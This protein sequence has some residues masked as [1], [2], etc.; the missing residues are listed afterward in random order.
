MTKV[1]EAIGVGKDYVRSA[2][3]R[4]SQHTLRDSLASWGKAVV[5][6][7]PKG[8]R[9]SERFSALKG[10]SFDLHEGE[11][12]G[13]LGPNGSGKSTLL[14][15]I[16]QVTAPTRGEVRIAGT[17]G[18][19]LEVGTG[20]HP[21]L[22]GRENVYLNG[23]IIGMSQAEVRR[24]FDEIVAFSGVDAFIDTP[25]KRYS[26]GMQVRLAFAIAAH[27][28][29]DI[30]ILDEVLA[31]GDASF[32]RSCMNKLK[33]IGSAGERAVILVS[34]SMAAIRS[35]CTKALLLDAGEVQ[36]YGEVDDVIDRYQSRVGGLRQDGRVDL[37]DW[38]NRTGGDVGARITWGEIR[39]EKGGSIEQLCLGDTIRVTF[40]CKLTAERAGKPI[41]LAVSITTGDGLPIAHMVD[42][43]SKF[44]IESAG[45]DEVVTIVLRD[46]RLYPGL[47]SLSFWIGT[48]DVEDLDHV[49]DCLT[50]E[51]KPGGL[52]N[53]SLP[54]QTGIIFLTPEW[55][56]A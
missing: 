23:A 33:E 52:T 38:K 27:I 37:D 34:H 2:V 14:K 39:P 26:S 53:R 42:R 54:R 7:L 4:G 41:R 25:V 1:I 16:S 46:L 28:E 51:I 17:I 19:L 30:L 8:H 20:F 47:Y 45:V 43:D 13:I 44:E 22:T 50:F 29:P 15:I 9:G 3:R 55:A 24:K 18:S 36:A 49:R 11:V 35:M 12:L 21:E 32:Q 5:A 48:H 31:V 56:R 6:R 10:V 40:G